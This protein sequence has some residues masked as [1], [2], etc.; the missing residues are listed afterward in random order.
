MTLFFEFGE[1]TIFRVGISQDFVFFGTFS[2]VGRPF[3]A[4]FGDVEGNPFAHYFLL[5]PRENRV[6]IEDYIITSD[7]FPILR[8][9]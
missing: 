4:I 3:Y 6:F 7:Q 9:P 2:A 1:R 5:V 8:V